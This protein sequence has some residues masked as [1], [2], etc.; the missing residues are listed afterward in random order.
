M[1]DTVRATVVGL[2]SRRSATEEPVPSTPAASDPTVTPIT[3]AAPV[4]VWT[5]RGS[6]LTPRNGTNGEDIEKLMMAEAEKAK[7]AKSA[8]QRPKSAAATSSSSTSSR[9]WIDSAP[10]T[11][12]A[13]SSKSGSTRAPLRSVVSVTSL[14]CNAPV[15]S[16]VQHEKYGADVL[17]AV[18][19]SR[20]TPHIIALETFPKASPQ[21]PASMRRQLIELLQPVSVPYAA[22]SASLTKGKLLVFPG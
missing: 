4:S 19:S 7:M 2:Q 11:T 1:L 3:Q 14:G 16:R 21:Q 5:G 10:A 17:R 9:E 12:A 15:C 22:S 6:H 20:S 18:C 13:S 8:R